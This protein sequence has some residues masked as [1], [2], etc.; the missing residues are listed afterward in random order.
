MCKEMEIINIDGSF[1]SLAMK[2]QERNT[3]PRDRQEINGQL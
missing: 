1:K 3:S 2:I